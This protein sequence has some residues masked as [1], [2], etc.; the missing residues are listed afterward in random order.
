MVTVLEECPIDKQRSLVLFCGQ[1]DS[2]Q[3]TFIKKCFLFTMGTLGSASRVKRFT[4][5]SRNS[6]LKKHLGGKMFADDEEL[7]AD[8]QKWLRQQK[9]SMLRVSPHW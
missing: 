7:E 4:T 2:M 8:V 6:P 9:T 3:R 5:G 1:K